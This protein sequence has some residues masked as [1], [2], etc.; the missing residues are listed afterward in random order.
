MR[1][2]RVGLTA[3]FSAALFGTTTFDTTQA[4][5]AVRLTAISGLRRVVVPSPVKSAVMEVF[6]G[7][8]R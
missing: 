7:S 5:D 4:A 6:L 1:V 3:A 2:T 8:C